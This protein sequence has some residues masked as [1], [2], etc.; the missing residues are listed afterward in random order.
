MDVVDPQEGTSSA[1]SHPSVTAPPKN[2]SRSSINIDNVK[3]Q[4]ALLQH[5]QNITKQKLKL[6]SSAPSSAY[7]PR[8]LMLTIK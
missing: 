2:P 8:L 3:N 7:I 4:A 6:N 5:L 1:T